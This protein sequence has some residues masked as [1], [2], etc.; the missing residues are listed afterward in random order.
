MTIEMLSY[1]GVDT[2][3]LDK[4]VYILDDLKVKAGCQAVVQQ[5]INERYLPMAIERKMELVG[6]WLFPPF[7]RPNKPADIVYLWR[8]DTLRAWWASRFTEETDARLP[9]FWK[10]AEQYLVSRSRRVGRTPALMPDAGPRQAT[11]RDIVPPAPGIRHIAIV[12]PLLALSPAEQTLWVTAAKSLHGFDGVTMS[13]AGFHV[14]FSYFPGQ[15]T[16][17][18]MAGPGEPITEQRL[19]ARLPGPAVMTQ[20][21]TIGETVDMASRYPIGPLEEKRTILFR[22]GDVSEAQRDLLESTLMEFARHLQGLRTWSLSR[23]SAVKGNVRWTH[24]WEQEFTEHRVVTDDYLYHPYHWTIADRFF[25]PEA[26]EK[27]VYEFVHTMR[28]C[29]SS[30]LSQLSA[31][32]QRKQ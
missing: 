18:V 30:L 27:T 15:M 23:L 11:I 26:T 14:E 19:L 12:E 5:L 2:Y 8:F 21:V 28:A 31:L 4:P 6:A 10:N 1:D 29:D 20:L 24:C 9:E 32:Q 3:G 13:E 7:E 22:I 17:D 25:G 16:W